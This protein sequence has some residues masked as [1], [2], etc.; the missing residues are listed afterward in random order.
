MNPKLSDYNYIDIN[1]IWLHGITVSA[2]RT[3]EPDDIK[4]VRF[5]KEK[6]V[7]II[8]WWDDTV[9]KVT[10]QEQYGDTFNPELGMAMCI[11]KKAFGGK[12]N[13]NDVFKKWLPQE[14]EGAE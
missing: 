6:G 5:N 14:E 4:L 2:L 12:G 7:T 11:C 8:K 1:D 13:Y 10:V 9:T 3:M